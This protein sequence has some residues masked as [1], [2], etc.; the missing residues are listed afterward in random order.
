MPAILFEIV[1]VLSAGAPL[2][3]R[4]RAVLWWAA[5][6]VVPCCGGR[7]LP[8]RRDCIL[9]KGFPDRML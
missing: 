1:C 2:L 8:L 5:Y 3:A 6:V 9:F 7:L 4:R